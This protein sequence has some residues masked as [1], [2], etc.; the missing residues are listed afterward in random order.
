VSERSQGSRLIKTA[1]F[2]TE[3]PSSSTSSSFP[4][5]QPQGL[6]ASIHWLGVNICIRLFQLLV[7]SFRG[8]S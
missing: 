8:Q 2:P 5:I 6:A 7:G 4:I 3:L 1:G